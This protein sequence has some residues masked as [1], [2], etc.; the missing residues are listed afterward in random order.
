MAE[1]TRQKNQHHAFGIKSLKAALKKPFQGWSTDLM[2]ARDND[3][4]DY[5]FASGAPRGT[6]NSC[7]DN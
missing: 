2:R 3:D 4:D 7:K 1:N 5:N 6:Q